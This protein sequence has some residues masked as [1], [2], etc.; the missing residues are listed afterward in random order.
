MSECSYKCSAKRRA[1]NVMALRVLEA[2]SSL[3]VPKDRSPLPESRSHLSC[4]LPL[5]ADIGKKIEIE[6]AL[7]QQ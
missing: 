5:V 2:L 4:N 6:H 7:S 1:L 3:A